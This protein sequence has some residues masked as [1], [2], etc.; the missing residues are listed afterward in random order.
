MAKLQEQF[1]TAIYDKPSDEIL[2]EIILSNVPKEELLG[3]YRNN[4]ECHLVN[5]LKLTFA[6]V[7][8][9]LKEEEFLE[10]ASEFVFNNPSKSNNLDDYGEG[11]AEFLRQKKDN[12]IADL[13]RLDWFKQKSYL[14]KNNDEFNLE[15]LQ[16]VSPKELFDLRF[17]LGDSVFL[18]ESDF[19]LL[20]NRYQK[21]K[22]IRKCYFLVFRHKMSGVFDVESLRIA[23]QEYKFLKGIEEKLTLY[24]IYE[25]YEVDI[26]NI[27]QKFLSNGVI[28]AFY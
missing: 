8:N 5:A 9:I 1:I 12:F 11:F 27:L 25:K 21:S 13:A 18:L 16:K 15:K 4:L 26:Q 7:F 19:N 17:V 2:D 22:M 3:I 20:A 28:A 10:L 23:P 14:A 6:G 24:E